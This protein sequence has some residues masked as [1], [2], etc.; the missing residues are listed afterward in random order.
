MILPKKSSEFISKGSVNKSLQNLFGSR[1][2]VWDRYHEYIKLRFPEKVITSQIIHMH[3]DTALSTASEESFVG[4]IQSFGFQKYHNTLN[5]H[6]L[7]NN[8]KELS[9]SFMD[10][11][12][13][14]EIQMETKENMGHARV[15]IDPMLR[16]KRLKRKVKLFRAILLFL[17]Q[18]KRANSNKKFFIL[19]VSMASLLIFCRVYVSNRF[20]VKIKKSLFFKKFIVFK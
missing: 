18:N 11:T 4:V 2:R 9:S 16:R 14:V 1:A 15:D 3:N 7:E 20:Y 13:E 5:M 8:H 6:E 10:K 19:L 17:R 12:I